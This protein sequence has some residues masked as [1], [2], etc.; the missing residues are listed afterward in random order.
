MECMAT[1]KDGSEAY[2]Y[3]R[4]IAEDIEGQDEKYRC[5]V[6]MLITVTCTHVDC[7]LIVHN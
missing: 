5:L 6:R 3:A 4:L 2:L 7:M 1:W